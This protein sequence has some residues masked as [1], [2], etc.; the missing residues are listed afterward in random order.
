MNSSNSKKKKGTTKPAIRL[1]FCKVP[2]L[3]IG[4]FGTMSLF[5]VFL[6]WE[7]E[8]GVGFVIIAAKRLLGLIQK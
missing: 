5:L 7:V 4:H 8:I 2:I 1:Q 3:M 6:L